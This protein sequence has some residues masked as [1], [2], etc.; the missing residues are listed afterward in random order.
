M[1][2]RGLL[3]LC[4][5]GHIVVRF[6]A[7]LMASPDHEQSKCAYPKTQTEDTAPRL[8]QSE[9]SWVHRSSGPGQTSTSS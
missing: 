8:L 1:P 3:S 2:L 6:I 9:R 7:L 4:R 5:E